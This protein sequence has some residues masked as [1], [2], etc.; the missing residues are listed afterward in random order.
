MMDAERAADSAKKIFVVVNALKSGKLKVHSQHEA[1]V[2]ELLSLP[3]GPTGLPDIS[4]ASPEAISFG[5]TAAI[6][7]MHLQAN[8]EPTETSKGAMPLADAQCKLFEFFENLFVAL[9]GVL[10]SDVNSPEEIKHQLVSRFTVSESKF[11][12]AVN[13]AVAELD[14]F[15]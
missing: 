12:D 11:F 10:A 8:E 5:R 7:L 4:R 14:A 3:T 2:S 9:T 13:K 6:A 1:L 15:Y